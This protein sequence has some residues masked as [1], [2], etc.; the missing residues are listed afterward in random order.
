V[1]AVIAAWLP[2]GYDWKSVDSADVGIV[3]LVLMTMII[4]SVMAETRRPGP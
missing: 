1:A 3:M 2:P 4:A